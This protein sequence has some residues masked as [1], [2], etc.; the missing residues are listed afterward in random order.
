M[1]AGFGVPRKFDRDR[2]IFDRRPQNHEEKRLPWAHLPLCSQLC[3]VILDEHTGVRGSGEDL[4]SYLN[5]LGGLDSWKCRNAFGRAFSGAEA[6]SLGGISAETY[7]LCLKVVPMGDINA[8]DL[9]QSCHEA[10]LIRY[11]GLKEEQQLIYGLPLPRGPVLEGVHIDDHI[12]IGLC[13]KGMLL[14]TVG[15][16]TACVEAS[17][18][19][20]EGHNVEKSPEKSFGFCA[21]PNSSACPNFTAWGTEVTSDPGTAGAPWVKRCQLFG[22]GLRLVSGDFVNIG[23]LRRFVACCIH[24]FMHFK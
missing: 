3:R 2:I 6:V 12:V 18:R 23:I 11:W 5:Q 24:P 9:A 7:R 19:A 21:G 14:N 4:K 13:Q 10:L 16:D 8:V 17:A 1:L 22:I 15:P 20:Y